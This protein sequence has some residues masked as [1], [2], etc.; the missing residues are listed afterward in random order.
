MN[1]NPNRCQPAYATTPQAS[2]S[3]AEKPSVPDRMQVQQPKPTGRVL[4]NW[5]LASF[6]KMPPSTLAESLQPGSL[7]DP[8]GAPA[9]DWLRFAKTPLSPAASSY[10]SRREPGDLSEHRVNPRPNLRPECGK[11]LWP[12]RYPQAIGFVSQNAP[13]PLQQEPGDPFGAPHELP[14]QLAPGWRSTLADRDHPQAKLASFRKKRPFH[15]P[16]STP[17][18]ARRPFRGTT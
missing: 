3:P 8:F 6:R 1:D 18:G 17:T 7:A 16:A 10:R 2:R 15:P 11:C 4:T 9:R 5:P 13:H 12:T 14:T